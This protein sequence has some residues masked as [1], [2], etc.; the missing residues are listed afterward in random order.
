MACRDGL[1]LAQVMRRSPWRFCRLAVGS[2]LTV[3]VLAIVLFA[4]AIHASES[5]ATGFARP[6]VLQQAQVGGVCGDRSNNALQNRG[7]RPV[8]SARLGNMPGLC[9][10]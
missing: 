8:G 10:E 7:R 9:D 5:A 6:A 2:V 4:P 1:A 3:A